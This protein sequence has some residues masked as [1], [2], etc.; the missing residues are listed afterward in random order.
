MRRLHLAIV[1]TAALAALALPGFAAAKPHHKHPGRPALAELHTRG[2]NGYRISVYALGPKAVGLFVDKGAFSISYELDG[3][4][5]TRSLDAN[6]GKLGHIS[7][8]LHVS[9]RHSEALPGDGTCP[10]SRLVHE[11]GV[12]R[13]SFNFR[14]EQGFTTVSAHHIPGEMSW[15]TNPRCSSRSA[16]ATSAR[17]PRPL[18]AS[19]KKHASYSAV[20]ADHP[21]NGRD[22]F[23]EALKE[24]PEDDEDWELFA[25]IDERRGRIDIHR[26][27]FVFAGPNMV[28]VSDPGVHPVSAEVVAKAPLQGSATFTESPIAPALPWEGSLRISMPGIGPVPL[29]G[30]GFHTTVCSEKSFSRLLGCQEAASLVAGD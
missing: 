29:T 18:R 7:L 17:V 15:A 30:Q 28:T 1:A 11:H 25:A 3:R 9:S 22:T 16:R 2:S 10:A 23:F 5:T 13:G 8:R 14:G 21:S 12:F 24:F 6:L 27:A 19:A 26:D 20:I 4:V